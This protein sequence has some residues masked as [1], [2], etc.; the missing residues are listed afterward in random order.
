MKENATHQEN[1]CSSSFSGPRPGEPRIRWWKRLFTGHETGSHGRKGWWRV[2][3]PVAVEGHSR[4]R[5]T[6]VGSRHKHDHASQVVSP[7][8]G[9]VSAFLRVT[10]VDTLW[11]NTRCSLTEAPV[12]PTTA[13]PASSKPFWGKLLENLTRTS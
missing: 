1:A 2:G 7:C 12:P 5:K 13:L 10:R 11:P 4:F 8:I 9:Q 3:T 6:G